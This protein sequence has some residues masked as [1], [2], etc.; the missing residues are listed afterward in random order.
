MGVAMGLATQYA[1]AIFG[2]V[3]ALSAATSSP[4]GTPAVAL[5][6]GHSWQKPGALSA[7]GVQEFE[8]NRALAE[9]IASAL[10]K[11]GFRV[12]LIGL[13][14]EMDDLTARPQRAAGADFFL[15]IHHDSVQLQYLESW[16]VAGK[17]HRYSDRFSGFSL[18]VSRRNPHFEQSIACAS[19]LG[20]TLRAAGF[21]PSP[22]HAEP[23][24]GES[25]PFADRENGVYYF[26][27]L[28]V[29]RAATLPAVL[30]EAGI[31]VNRADEQKLRQ[32]EMQARIAAALANGLER[33]L[34]S[35]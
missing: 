5:D 13:D 27:D 12:T 30:L 9:T 18:F 35:R 2:I 6:V 20:A 10:R 34:A 17:T 23:I 8:F 15:S 3:A 31:I 14:G 11:H 32:P 19:I 24:P 28:V 7:R 21:T 29:L 25:R 22:H 16:T 1:P 26:D 33:C 4:I